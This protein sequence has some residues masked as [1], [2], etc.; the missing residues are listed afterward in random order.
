MCCYY[1]LWSIFTSIFFTGKKNYLTHD[2]W[3]T[4]ENCGHVKSHHSSLQVSLIGS[5]IIATPSLI[6]WSILPSPALHTHANTR[7]QFLDKLL[8]LLVKSCLVT[9]NTFYSCSNSHFWPL[10]D[11]SLV[12]MQIYGLEKNLRQLYLQLSVGQRL[13]GVI[14]ICDINMSILICFWVL[15]IWGLEQGPQVLDEEVK[16]QKVNDLPKDAQGP[17]VLSAF[18]SR[19]IRFYFLLRNALHEAPCYT[20]LDRILEHCSLCFTSGPLHFSH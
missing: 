7:W 17:E 15:K 2:F 4:R 14:I 19:L 12:N 6:S 13:P 5:D 8:Y 20:S 18:I 16:A 1:I 9:K 11:S 10:T 3:R